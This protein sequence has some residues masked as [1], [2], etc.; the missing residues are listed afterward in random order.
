M[1][2]LLFV[3]VHPQYS[4]TDFKNDVALIKLDKKVIFKHHI[5]PVCL[6][7]LNVKLVGK[8]ATVAG[9]GRTRHGV[10]TVPTVLQEVDVEVIPNERC[11]RWFRS[12]GRRE[13]IHDVFL[14]AGFKE[15]GRDS[16][17]VRSFITMSSGLAHSWYLLRSLGSSGH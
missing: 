10:A 14:C 3:Q 11:Q 9:W 5:I 1:I 8:T 15:G 16:C 6:P 17:Q 12:A 13:T 4:A 7:E 2:F